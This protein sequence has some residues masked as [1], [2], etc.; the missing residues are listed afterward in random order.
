MG[1]FITKRRVGL[2]RGQC[3][4]LIVTEAREVV[5]LLLMTDKRLADKQYIVYLWNPITYDTTDY[6]VRIIDGH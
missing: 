2:Y 6:C 4:K 3:E 5:K 1:L